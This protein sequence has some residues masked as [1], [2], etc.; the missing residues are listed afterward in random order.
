[1]ES[2]Y[3]DTT[4][5]LAADCAFQVVEVVGEEL[6]RDVFD[7]LAQPEA[8]QRAAATPGLNWRHDDRCA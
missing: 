2:R 6:A 5:S 8:R 3:S 1:L 4:T 7:A